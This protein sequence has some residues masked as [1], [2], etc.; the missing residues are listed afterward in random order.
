M[1]RFFLII[2]SITSFLYSQSEVYASGS[3]S[4]FQYSKSL[5]TLLE[6]DRSPSSDLED[7]RR[8]RILDTLDHSLSVVNLWNQK[9]TFDMT[10]TYVPYLQKYSLSCEIAALHM[11]LRRSGVTESEDAL[12]A[13][14]PFS[15]E[16]YTG[17]V[18]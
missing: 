7:L 5:R 12:I 16:A 1:T 9:P 6:I 14:L 3:V 4:S 13:R 11:V 10:L 17:G 15:L 2:L 18:W 8:I